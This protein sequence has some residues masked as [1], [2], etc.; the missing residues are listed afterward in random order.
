[1]Y[2]R[3]PLVRPVETVTAGA[4]GLPGK[5]EVYVFTDFSTYMRTPRY[6]GALASEGYCGPAVSEEQR[7][8]DACAANEVRGAYLARAAFALYG[9]DIVRRLEYWRVMQVEQP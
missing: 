1:M 4:L 8:L 9:E 3:A 2:S 6:G 5:T 7:I